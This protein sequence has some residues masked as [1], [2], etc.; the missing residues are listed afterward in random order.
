MKK[1]KIIVPALA[2]I[3]FS[4]A[5]S[6]TGS[7]AWFTAN[8][9]ATI[10]AGTYTVVKTTANLDYQLTAGIGTYLDTADTTGSTIL[11]KSMYNSSLVD[12]K[13]T[14]G[15]FD[16]LQSNIYTP[17]ASVDTATATALAS[18]TDL[19]MTR[20]ELD[21]HGKVYTAVTFTAVFK[22]KF[23]SQANNIGLFFDIGASSFT[24]ADAPASGQAASSNAASKGFRMAFVGTAG[25]NSS[26]YV[27]RVVAPLQTAANCKYV[28][29]TVA[30]DLITEATQTDPEVVNGTAYTDPY[31]MD[32][33]YAGSPTALPADGAINQT[34]AAARKDYLGTFNFLE[35]QEVSLTY[36]IVAWFEGTDSNVV[37]DTVLQAVTSV[38]HFKAIN[39]SLS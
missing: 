23:A 19:N 18:A 25:T 34:A 4:M 12:N 30:Q 14:D 17:D 29:A 26:T 36:T 8:R 7:V 15:S 38:L 13:L 33:A 37:N 28:D 32:S 35:N 39:L 21:T 10:N 16:H 31:L 22:I 2:L 20:A 6:I 11:V 24:A 5:A 3:A 1:S 27:S 9:Q